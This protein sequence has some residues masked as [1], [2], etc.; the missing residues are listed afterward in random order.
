MDAPG[1]GVSAVVVD[2][3]QLLLVRRGRAPAAGLWSFPGGRLE[4]GE[5]IE[6]G[7]RRELLEECGIEVD[8]GPLLAVVEVVRDEEGSPHHWIVLD[9]LASVA[10]GEVVA[11]D[12]AEEARWFTL[13]EIARLMTTPR[14]GEVAARALAASKSWGGS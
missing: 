5:S 10:A 1:V 2:G 12:D 9:Y 3:E 8:L 11:G 6:D 4:L 14:V 13:A 7:A